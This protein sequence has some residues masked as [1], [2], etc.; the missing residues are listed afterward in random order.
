MSSKGAS[1]PQVSITV[2]T[3]GTVGTAVKLPGAVVIGEPLRI[4]APAPRGGTKGS[5]P[6]ILIAGGP[7]LLTRYGGCI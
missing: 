3:Y 7:P 2:G 5:S 1:K 4:A 6:Y